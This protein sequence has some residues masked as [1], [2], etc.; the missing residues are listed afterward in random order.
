M[1]FR[2]FAATQSDGPCNFADNP[3]IHDLNVIKSH[4]FHRNEQLIGVDAYGGRTKT[5]G[6]FDPMIRAC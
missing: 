1:H 4:A 5:A 6:R 3:G 2:F